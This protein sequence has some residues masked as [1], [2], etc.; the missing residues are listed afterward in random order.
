MPE[1]RDRLPRPV[2]Y[3][4]VFAQRRVAGTGVILEDQ[5]TGPILFE[6]PIRRVTTG[7][8]PATRGLTALGTARGGGLGRG[9]F[10]T[11]RSMRRRVL[12]GSPATGRANTPTTS[13]GSGR[14]R[15]SGSV[16]PSWYPRVPLQDITSVVRAIQRRRARLGNVEGLQF[17]SPVPV[18]QRILD[19][20]E[21]VSG[22]QLEHDLSFIS[23]RSAAA[24]KTK[25]SA[26]GKVPKILLGV[27]NQNAGESE[28]LT[29][30]KKLLNSIDIVEK[31]V[32][33]EL[34]KLERTPS[35]K[36]VEREKRVR[37]L[38]SMR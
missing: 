5:E 14:G 2:D 7:T 23:P 35:A 28:L 9:G 20:S 31:E 29:P 3:A 4:A 12:H 17:E 37:T 38:M 1:S 27:T 21:L 13:R 8:T 15:P 26:V 6:T 18:G 19:P 30:Q 10:G 36:K 25:K 24:V 11:P 22:A 34:Q 33:E 16:L 32:M